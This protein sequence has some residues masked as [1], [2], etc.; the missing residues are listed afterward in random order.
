MWLSGRRLAEMI[1]R[2]N[3]TGLNWSVIVFLFV[4][5]YLFL[6]LGGVT[7]L[8]AASLVG[9][10]PMALGARRAQLMGFFLVPV[11]L[12]YSGHQAEIVE[13][14]SIEARLNESSSF[15]TLNQ[16][17]L[18]TL[19]AIF[20]GSIVYLY[21]AKNQLKFIGGIG[22]GICLASISVL[23]ALLTITGRSFPGSDVPPKLIDSAPKLIE[24]RIVRVVDGDTL[25]IDS[26]GRR[27]RIRLHGID[28]P[29]F[30]KIGKYDRQPY[31]EESKEWLESQ[32]AR[33]NIEWESV[34]VDPFGRVLA[35]VYKDK[36]S[37]NLDLVSNGYAWVFPGTTRNL[38]ALKVAEDEAVKSKLG[39][40]AAKKTPKKPW[41]WR[42][43]GD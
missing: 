22:V 34:G 27:H 2:L 7:V 32:L 12:Y 29:E 19:C 25:Y 38:K 9:L 13:F 20:F 23:M 14:L 15:I 4:L 8:V 31:A 18:S 35:V 26:F 39:L 10:L 16:I 5:T 21:V 36:R 40:W 1:N 28:A 3:V 37:V 24:G 6:G 30:E 42:E 33:S 41:D 11:L 43:N 17:M